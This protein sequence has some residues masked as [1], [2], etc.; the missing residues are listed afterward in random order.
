MP[1]SAIRHVAVDHVLPL[2]RIPAAL[3]E[4]VPGPRPPAVE[5]PDRIR[6]EALIAAQEI[7]DMEQFGR[8]GPLS[9]IT[10]PECHGAMQEIREGGLMRYRCHTGHA[11]TLEALGVI[12]ADAWERALYSALRAQQERSIVVRRMA[13][14][15]R[16]GGAARTAEQL[17]ERAESYEEGVELLRRL[18]AHGNRAGEP[19]EGSEA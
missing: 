17:Q 13:D 16:Q 12:Q 11:F 3:A 1:R 6:A 10:C 18:I 19:I 14:Q 4:L 2:E 7:P 9:P 5:V 8:V 15:A